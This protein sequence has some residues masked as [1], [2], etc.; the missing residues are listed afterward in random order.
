MADIR[1][2]AFRRAK[3]SGRDDDWNAY[4]S[5]NQQL[6]KARQNKRDSWKAFVKELDAASYRNVTGN[7]A[8]VLLARKGHARRNMSRYA[9]DADFSHFA[10]SFAAKL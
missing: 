1:A 10:S 2:R 5:Q 3:Q 6:K 9:E 7:V 8:G 4:E